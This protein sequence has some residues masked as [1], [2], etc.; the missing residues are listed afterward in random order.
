V[1]REKDCKHETSNLDLLD[2]RAVLA[3]DEPHL[4]VCDLQ[5]ENDEMS[6]TSKTT[7]ENQFDEKGKRGHLVLADELG[8]L[9][10]QL[11]LL[12]VDKAT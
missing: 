12:Q 6:G 8:F 5:A 9:R 3:D 1:D 7:R 10:V 11:V 2:S 4:G